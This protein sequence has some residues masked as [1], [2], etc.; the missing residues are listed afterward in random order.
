MRK[1]Y[2]G[3]IALLLL[4]LNVF[5]QPEA[6]KKYSLISAT[7]NADITIL[8]L[9]DPY[10]SPLSYSGFGV[11]YGHV[12]RK[13]FNPENVNYSM[14]SKLNALAGI[15]LNPALS[16]AMTYIGGAYSWGAFYHYRE[17]K[18]L[19][20]LAGSTAEGQLGLKTNTRNVNN[21]VNV[22]MAVNINLAAVL[23]YDLKT[24]RKVY[25]LNYEL[26]TPLFGCM[27]VPLVG[28]SYYEMFELGNLSNAV[29]FSS[30]HNKT[31]LKSA[32]TID[33][34]MR[35]STLVCGFASQSLLY[36]ANDLVFKL[37]TF[38]LQI[39][40]KYDLYIF[41]GKKNPAPANFISTEK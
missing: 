21:P 5:A 27:Y 8:S 35:R 7:D 11:G 34:P 12:E 2:F 10:L 14:Q 13:Y 41:K 3:L 23:H 39:G 1:R 25:R 20:I 17:L 22:D 36:K 18:N 19:H 24:R 4:C 31:G 28:A 37:N 33:I 40:Y 6:D 32:L 16:S 29:H 38:S 15:A 9:T 26:E 30:L